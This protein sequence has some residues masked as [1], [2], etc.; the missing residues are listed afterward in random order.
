MFQAFF[1]FD[2]R[3][4]AAA[5][6]GDAAY[7]FHEERHGGRSDVGSAEGGGHEAERRAAPG[8]NGIEG[9]VPDLGSDAGIADFPALQADGSPLASELQ[10]EIAR[11]L[12]DLE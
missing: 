12:S 1:G 8:R 5:Q 9:G 7:G 4:A 6:F 10:L 11:L 2:G 3:H